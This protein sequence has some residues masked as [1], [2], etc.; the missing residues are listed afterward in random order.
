MWQPIVK[1]TI[2]LDKY[3]LSIRDRHLNW[4]A[5]TRVITV[6]LKCGH[7]KEYRCQAPKYKAWCKKCD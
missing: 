2:K 7:T 6:R 3:K 1:R 4:S 5:G